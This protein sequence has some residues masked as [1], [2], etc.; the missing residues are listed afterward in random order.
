[1]KVKWKGLRD[2]YRRELKKQRSSAN[3]NAGHENA[4]DPSWTHYSSMNFLREYMGSSSNNH[5]D[6]F[7]FH[8]WSADEMSATA[9]DMSP[10]AD[11]TLGTLGVSVGSVD[12][13][14]PLTDTIASI[15]TKE[16]VSS[17]GESTIIKSDTRT[18]TPLFATENA[19]KDLSDSHHQRTEMEIEMEPEVRTQAQT[20][21]PKRRSGSERK[22]SCTGRLSSR[23]KEHRL[24]TKLT[25]K[26]SKIRASVTS[27][28]Q[29]AATA[30]KSSQPQQH[31]N[32][33]SLPTDRDHDHDHNSHHRHHHHHRRRRHCHRHLEDS[34]SAS[35]SASD[36]DDDLYF[37]KSLIP[38]V[39]NLPTPKKLY[40]R[41]EIHNLVLRE[42]IGESSSNGLIP[43]EHVSVGL[44]A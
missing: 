41:A 35:A 44:N 12:T 7:L 43:L 31:P 11:E 30:Y 14:S 24:R 5:S 39:K 18:E 6:L 23:L 42:V 17:D 13:M 22:R 8:G 27:H 19:E 40:L 37:F 16:E 33:Q 34:T 29:R 1:M 32:H 2:T 21:F 28:S 20:T 3:V 36:S 9:N 26:F 15:K 38:Y 25:R 4:R 10:T